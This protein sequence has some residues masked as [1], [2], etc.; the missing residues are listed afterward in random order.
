MAAVDL[1][2]EKRRS[3]PV[4][5]QIGGADGF[6]D[7]DDPAGGDVNSIGRPWRNGGRGFNSVS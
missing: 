6:A 4:G 1:D 3:D 2:V 7:G 5:G